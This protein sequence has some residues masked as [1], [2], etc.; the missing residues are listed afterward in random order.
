MNKLKDQEFVQIHYS[1]DRDLCTYPKGYRFEHV[2]ILEDQ[3]GNFWIH[4]VGYLGCH[5]W[6][7]LNVYQKSWIEIQ[8]LKING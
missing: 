6:V 7:K 4:G 8:L 3:V 2:R 1:E 5:A